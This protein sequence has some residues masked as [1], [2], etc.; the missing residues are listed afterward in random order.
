MVSHGMPK[1]EFYGNV[2]PSA[3]RIECCGG[4]TIWKD[5]NIR[6]SFEFSIQV[7]SVLIGCTV[8]EVSDLVINYVHQITAIHIGGIIDAIAFKNGVGLRLLI[9]H[10]KL[11]DQAPRPLKSGSPAFAPLCPF[12]E[13]EVIKFVEGERR[14]LKPL[15]DLVQTLFNPLDSFV[16]CQ[17]AIEG[18]AR[19]ISSDEE[20]RQK[21]W[22]NLRENLNLSREYVQPISDQ[23]T[24]YRHG[25]TGPISMVDVGMTHTK[26]WIIT[27]R[28]LEFRKRGNVKLPLSEFPV[29]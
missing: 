21:R 12:T 13:S 25:Y 15:N 17:R 20:N 19:L 1:I 3:V 27:A 6:F 4:P 23:S 9:D 26:A 5:A 24:A 2:F 8:D 28:F 10:C 18:L 11:P 29:L 7:S 22:V 16:N 14:L